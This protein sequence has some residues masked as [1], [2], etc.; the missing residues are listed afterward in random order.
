MLIT[1]TTGCCSSEL[2]SG[3]LIQMLQLKQERG[4][5]LKRWLCWCQLEQSR[6]RL[7]AAKGAMYKACLVFVSFNV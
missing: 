6:Q 4:P 3:A 5:L 2:G 1:V 7:V